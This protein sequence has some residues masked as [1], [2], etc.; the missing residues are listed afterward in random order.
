[1]WVSFLHV[2]VPQWMTGAYGGHKKVSDPQL[3][4]T[5]WML[6]IELSSSKIVT[7]ALN[8]WPISPDSFFAILTIPSYKENI[9]EAN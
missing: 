7:S 8:H 1:M 9:W 3:Q 4:A 5:M 2:C 6:G